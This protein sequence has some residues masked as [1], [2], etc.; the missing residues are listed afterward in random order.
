MYDTS[1]SSWAVRTAE[2]TQLFQ[3]I[4]VD[5][6]ALRYVARTATSRLYDQFTLTKQGPGKPNRLTEALPPERRRAR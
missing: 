2:D 6:D 5:G 4:T 3:V 1:G